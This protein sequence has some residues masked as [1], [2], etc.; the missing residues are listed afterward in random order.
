MDPMG[1][2]QYRRPWCSADGCLSSGNAATYSNL[3]RIP[4]PVDRTFEA[5][6][7][8][9]EGVYLAIRV[10]LGKCFMRR[11]FRVEGSW[12]LESYVNPFPRAGQLSKRP[13]VKSQVALMQL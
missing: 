2:G 9:M 7:A 13:F 12:Y 4:S 10:S 1:A 11:K 3:S 5:K 6:S 8:S